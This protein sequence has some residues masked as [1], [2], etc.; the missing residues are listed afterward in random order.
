MNTD[1]L[2]KTLEK[3]D[4]AN[5]EDPSLETWQGETYPK[6]WL[7]GQRMSEWLAML[8]PNPSEERQIAARAQH[9]RRWTVPRDSYPEGREGYLRWRKYLYRFH[10]E[11]AAAIMAELGYGQ[12]SIDQVKQMIGK[13]GIKRHADVQV[14]EDAA[15]LVFLEYYF[16]D[17]A[18]KYEEDKLIDIVQKTWKK[19][20]AEG[21]Q[22]A[23]S[24]PLPDDLGTVVAKALAG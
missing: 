11:Q 21:Q 9:I 19:M 17:F 8:D 5:R 16:P 18:A 14:I 15:C 3:I 20:S 24:L 6:E 1:R 10:A 13:E 12:D 23:L 7:Y 4:Q 22:M 2:L